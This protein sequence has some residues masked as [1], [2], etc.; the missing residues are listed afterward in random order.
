[1][2]AGQ[3]EMYGLGAAAQRR[4]YLHASVVFKSYKYVAPDGFL[5]HEIKVNFT[6]FQIKTICFQ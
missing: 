4:R 6:A 2:H 1:M 3:N 5:A